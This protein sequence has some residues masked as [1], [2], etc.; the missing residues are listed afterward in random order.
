MSIQ[1]IDTLAK[2]VAQ[3]ILDLFLSEKRQA[4]P[5]VYVNN[6]LS[7]DFEREFC[8]RGIYG[9]RLTKD[10]AAVIAYIGKTENDGRIRQHL[11]SL[12]KDG[13]P[14]APSVRTKYARIQE[15]VL[16]GFAVELC[17]F[18]D[19]AFTKASLAC[20]EIAAE[21]IALRQC[22][23]TFPSLHPWINRI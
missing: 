7:G 22:Q 14:L 1:Q 18:A 20:V 15:A 2:Q 4:K 19:P 23:A 12:N 21:E 3:Q 17:L 16:N 9:F 8:H 10:G 6:V 13:T 5:L 11:C